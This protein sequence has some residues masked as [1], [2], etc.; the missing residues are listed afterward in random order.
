[1]IRIVGG[2]LP[3]V[4]EA[5]KDSAKHHDAVAKRFKTKEKHSTNR[6]DSYLAHRAAMKHDAIAKAKR[7][8]K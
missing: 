8:G 7:G 2:L 6:R 5:T 1:M 3:R 4:S